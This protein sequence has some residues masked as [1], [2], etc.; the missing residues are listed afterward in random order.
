MVRSPQIMGGPKSPNLGLGV[1]GLGVWC[2]A[3]RVPGCTGGPK[4][5]PLISWDIFVALGFLI[6]NFSI[7][8]V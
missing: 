1:E 6:E 2:L 7:G 3:F 5:S 4:S 8:A